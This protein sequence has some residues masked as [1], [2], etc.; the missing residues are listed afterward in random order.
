VPYGQ[1][2]GGLKFYGDAKYPHA[3]LRSLE[4]WNHW[5]NQ[6]E[7]EQQ[8]A[9]CE[10]MTTADN[11]RLASAFEILNDQKGVVDPVALYQVAARVTTA[12]D[13]PAATVK[14]AAAAMADVD[15]CAEKHAQA[16]RKSSGTKSK[17]LEAKPWIGHLP[18]VLRH[19]TG[20]PACDALAEEWHNTL[21]AQDKVADKHA[22]AFW[23]NSGNKPDKAFAAGVKLVHDAFLTAAAANQEMLG[24]LEAWN[25]DAKDLGIGKADQKLFQAGVPV[26]RDAHK[27]GRDAFEKVSKRFR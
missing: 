14:A 22:R 23:Q 9:W 27:Q 13:M 7:T 16:I 20:V 15:E 4:G 1:S 2:I 25:K 18:L 19:F 8:L 11:T 3:R 26:L 10:G 21:E 17:K 24:K 5:P 12:A 6:S